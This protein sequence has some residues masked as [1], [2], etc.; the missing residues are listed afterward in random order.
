MKILIITDTFPPESVGGAGQVAFDMAKGFSEIGHRVI[1]LTTSRTQNTDE[2]S[3]EGYKI[4]RIKFNYK[5]KFL[6]S[7]LSVYNPF[8]HRKV[9]NIVKKENPDVVHCHNLHEFFSFAAIN[10]VKC[11]GAPVF[12]TAH[13]V[14]SFSYTR[15]DHNAGKQGAGGDYQVSLAL[16][17]NQ[18]GKSFN[19][20]RNPLIKRFIN[21]NVNKVFAVS[22]ALKT[23]LKQNGIARV[24]TLHN[25]I[26]VSGFACDS[27][28]LGSFR[29]R[30]NLGDK[31]VIFFG[32]R[33]MI[34]KGTLVLLDAFREVIAK[35]SDTC[36][37]MAMEEN[38]HTRYIRSISADL[39]EKKLLV[40]PGLLFGKELISMFCSSDVVVVPSI[41]FD[42]APLMVMQAMASRKPVVGTCF[43][44][45]PEILKN[46]ETGIVV[47][48]FQVSDLAKALL[49]I[50][51]N[52][53][54]AVRMGEAGFKR[55]TS[56]F[57]L[58]RQLSETLR[59]YQDALLSGKQFRDNIT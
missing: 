51:T 42:P 46:G 1:I 43:G 31:K 6:R 58:D 37:V 13:D 53:D 41:Y 7:Y 29:S 30:Y 25:G 21:R 52:P 9:V 8:L 59:E 35:N 16:L 24:Q 34:D 18:A 39:V 40:L 49:L 48:P 36:L 38:Q 2:I 32:G 3:P 19:P 45:T 47:D 33:A 12:L 55:L 15:L 20:F 14:M 10:W 23:A 17:F 5:I 28:E 4:I 26:N 54:R 27:D 56:F 44:G 57:S 22:D 11:T 50:L